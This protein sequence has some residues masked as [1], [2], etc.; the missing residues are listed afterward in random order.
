[1]AENGKMI[2][3]RCGVEMNRHAEKIDYAAALAD[4]EAFDPDFGGAVEEFHTC[5]ECGQTLSRRAV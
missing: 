3:P 1:M 4:P 5:P 2:C